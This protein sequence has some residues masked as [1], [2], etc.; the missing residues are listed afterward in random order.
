ML[1]NPDPN[2]FAFFA[3][4]FWPVVGLCL[5]QVWPAAQAAVWTFLGAYLLL[6]VGA[7]I[8]FQGIP[9]FDKDT[10]ASIAVVLGIVLIKRRSLR[11]RNGFGLTE[12]LVLI[13][14]IAPLI[15]DE[16]NTDPIILPHHNLPAGSFYDGLSATVRQFLLL[17]PFFVGRQLLRSAADVQMILRTLVIAGLLYSFPILFELR[18]SSQLHVWVYGYFPHMF[19]EM[20]RDG[21]FRPVVFIGHGLGV[22]FFVMT[23][24]IAATALWRCR[25]RIIQLPPIGAT[26]YLSAILI[27]CKGLASIVYGVVGL[28]LVRFASIRLQSLIAVGLVTAALSYP[29]LRTAGLVPTDTLVGMA[30]RISENR[31]ISLEERFDN[32]ER[33]LTRAWDRI[34]FGWG[35]YGRNRIYDPLTGKDNSATDGE[36]II[37]IGT[38]GLVGFLAEFG[39]LALP[40]FRIASALRLVESK[41]DG[42]Y[43]AALTLI[44][45]I[46]TFDLLP[47][48]SLTSFTWL[49]AGALLGRAEALKAVSRERPQVPI[50]VPAEQQPVKALSV[51]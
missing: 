44:S 20:V 3:L 42:I 29:L 28:I 24:V 40:V 26:G 41:Q 32:E 23:T 34:Y 9:Q 12:L 51:S 11:L 18:M 38:F 43:L 37:T 4:A 25:T 17:I 16:L 39:L 30:Q 27:L 49:I 7:A 36:W 1:T 46:N 22:A 14:L 15:T 45:A 19:A 48:A 10:I 47:N 50:G 13:Y 2:W 33:L 21:G 5:F 31:A 35:R 6:P 8:H